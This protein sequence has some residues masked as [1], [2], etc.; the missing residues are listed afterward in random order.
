MN[1]LLR[2]L[3]YALSGI[4]ALAIL[5]ALAVFVISEL[6]LR[7]SYDAPARALVLP[8]DPASIAEGKRLATL[9]GCYGG[10]HGSA[11]EG[12]VFIDEPGVARIVAPNLTAAVRRYS[13]AELE[14]IIRRGVKPDGRSVVGMPSG[15]FTHLTDTD[16]ARTIAFLRSEPPVEGPG[17]GIK[18]GPLARLG[19]VIGQYHPEVY[20]VAEAR[21]TELPAADTVA[22]RGRYLAVTICTECHGNDLRGS[23]DGSTPDLRIAAAYAPGTFRHLLRTGEPQGGRDLRLMDDVARGR[24]RHLTD[25]EIHALYTFLR[26]LADGTPEAAPVPGE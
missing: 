9:R 14:R 23:P 16:L 7:R 13:D 21:R 6:T 3:L 11:L 19:L 22:Q 12:G 1:R 8:A 17:P 10:C 26:G 2:W 15:M 18:L 24:F 25:D 20:Y 5:G 4:I